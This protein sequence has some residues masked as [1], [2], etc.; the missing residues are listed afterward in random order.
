MKMPMFQR[1]VL[2]SWIRPHYTSSVTD[3]SPKHPKLAC[4]VLQQYFLIQALLLFLH[5]IFVY[6]RPFQHLKSLVPPDHWRTL[7]YAENYLE[8]LSRSIHVDE[9]S[10]LVNNEEVFI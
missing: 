9:E 4:L 3:I 10:D 6:T 1:E 8:T 2:G 5:Y 7:S